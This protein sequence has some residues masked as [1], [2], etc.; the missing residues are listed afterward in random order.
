MKRKIRVV[1]KNNQGSALAWVLVICL[2]FAVL[3]AAI[4]WVALSMNN[5]SIKN[6]NLNQAY[7]T[8][9]SGANTIY[10]RLNGYTSE[11]SDSA[12][13]N[14]LYQNLVYG[15]KLKDK[16]YSLKYDDIFKNSDTVNMGT[17]DVEAVMTQG[18]AQF[19]STATY[20]GS[21]ETVILQAY[22]NPEGYTTWPAEEWAS[23]LE[24]ADP[25]GAICVGQNASIT[26][27]LSEENVR[28]GLMDVAV[29]KVEKGKDLKG[30]LTI[31]RDSQSL[32]GEK[33]ENL[34]KRAVFIYLEE[35]TTLTLTGMDYAIFKGTAKQPTEAAATDKWFETK[36]G[37]TSEDWENYY[38]PDIFIYLK[39]GAK[40]IFEKTNKNVEGE[41]VHYPLYI[42]GAAT[43]E[44]EKAP[45][46]NTTQSLDVMIYF[47][48]DVVINPYN[49]TSNWLKENKDIA[50]N[51]DEPSIP[52]R[53]TISGYKQAGIPYEYGNKEE[54]TK[55]ADANN[56]VY[57]YAGYFPNKWEILKYERKSIQ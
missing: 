7:F 5:R 21:T 15:N 27:E 51:K 33:T 4:G 45:T 9:L 31:C 54:K 30:K 22:R 35:N 50:F 1:S 13:Y 43:K 46:I 36:D 34:E 44:N 18:K 14:D 53:N 2:I 28:K 47:T 26:N 42:K 8:A 20:N 41:V 40:L 56:G 29:Y 3:G 12:L 24:E 57:N 49:G 38:G 17:C 39:S 25:S 48:Q 11:K 52:E 16:D 19:T 37:Y 55:A 10:S 6:D 23:T 32:S